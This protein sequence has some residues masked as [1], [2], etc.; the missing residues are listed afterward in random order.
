MIRKVLRKREFPINLNMPD[1][2]G[3]TPLM[4]AVKLSHHH[5]DY[6]EI[7]NCLISYGADPSAKDGNGWSC[8][9]EAVSQVNWMI[10]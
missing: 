2:L 8:L 10:L 4:L 5:I 9:D 3:N 1:A 6:I 7:A